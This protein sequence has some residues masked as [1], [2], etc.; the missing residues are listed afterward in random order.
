ML[1]IHGGPEAQE[2]PL[3]HPLYQYLLSRGI[4]VLATNIRG[5]TGYGKSYQRLIQRDW[6]GGD[7]QDWEHAVK[8]LHE[9]DWVDARAHRRLRR[10][11]RRLRGAHLRD[12]AA[13][14]L[15]GRGRHLRP[16]E[17]RH[18]REGRAADLEAVDEAV[19]RRSRRRTP[20]FLL[21][22]SPITYVENVKA[23]LLVIQGA[24]DPRVVKA[25]SDQMV[26]KLRELGREVEY[27]VFEDEGHGFTKRQNELKAYRLAADWLERHLAAG[28]DP[29]GQ[30]RD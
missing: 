13:G 27:V 24:K 6:G 17:P 9:Q 8:W 18:V 29:A 28:S 25:E 12:A 22:R 1:S 5:S 10:L 7:M 2:R 20:D 23:P 15:G 19:R 16:V 26:E 14:L 4:A 30:S 3:Y 11:V 21:E